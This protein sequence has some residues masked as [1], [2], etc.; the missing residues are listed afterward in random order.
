MP[1]HQIT[2][3]LKNKLAL[4]IITIGVLIFFTYGW[5]GFATITK[6][7]GLTGDLYVYYHVSQTG[8]FLYNLLVASITISMIVILLNGLIKGKPRMIKKG[9]WIFLVLAIILTIGE[10]YLNTRFTG[11]P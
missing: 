9:Y 11:K 10:I 6:R 8:F 3:L 5:T 4:I 7:S 1:S 2:G